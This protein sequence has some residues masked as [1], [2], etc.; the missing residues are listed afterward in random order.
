[1]LVLRRSLV[2]WLSQ[3]FH[4]VLY[5]CRTLF[6]IFPTVASRTCTDPGCRGEVSM[7]PGTVAEIDVSDGLSCQEYTQVWKIPG[8]LSIYLPRKGPTM[9]R[10]KKRMH[11]TFLAG[12]Q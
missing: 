5:E 1:M 2:A 12:Y 4:D 6:A 3:V 8:D 11:S 10:S 9:R 7:T